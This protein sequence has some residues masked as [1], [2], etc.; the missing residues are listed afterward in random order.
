ML[1]IVFV[2]R[3]LIFMS[4]CGILSLHTTV[5]W[6]RKLLHVTRLLTIIIVAMLKHEGNTSYNCY[7]GHMSLFKPCNGE[8]RGKVQSFKVLM[9]YFRSRVLIMLCNI[10]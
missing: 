3:E 7:Y 5:R 1:K 9:I 8:F 10:C 2:K 6:Q 4:H